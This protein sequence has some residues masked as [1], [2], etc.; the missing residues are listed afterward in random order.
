MA[1]LDTVA[2]DDTSPYE[3]CSFSETKDSYDEPMVY[4]GAPAENCG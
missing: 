2:R 4:G 1:A 3:P